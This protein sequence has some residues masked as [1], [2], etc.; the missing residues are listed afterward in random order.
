MTIDGYRD[1]VALWA[2]VTAQAKTVSKA[3]GVET[4]AL[5]RQFVF[6]RF[7]A[8]VFYDST[9]PWV[10]KGGI[11]V[12]AR[13]NDARATKDIDLFGQ[14]GSLEA[15]FDALRAVVDRDLK[16]HCRFVIVKVETSLGGAVQAQVD[17]Y[18]VSVDAYVG[19]V[20]KASFGVDL[21]TGALM[22]AEPELAAD[23]SLRLRGLIAPPMRLYPVVDHIA[24]KLCATQASYG[25]AGDRA[26]SRV[27]DLVDLV[28]FARTQDVDGSALIVAISGEWTHRELA[29]SP[30]FAPP[31]AWDRTYLP[32]ARK[33]PACAG[34]TSFPAA[35]ELIATFLGPAL[36]GTALGRRWSADEGAWHPI[37]GR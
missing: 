29:G 13:V 31:Q 14:L 4:G 33:V 32:L 36:D 21:V 12:L 3:T 1:G 10:L 7:L 18:R 23:S 28:I 30:Q 34:M 24:D 16:D 27:R 35:V 20:K 6:G 5:V 25:A 8:R 11:A 15:A 22:T 2:A 19:A 26:S 9:S 17:G 37:V